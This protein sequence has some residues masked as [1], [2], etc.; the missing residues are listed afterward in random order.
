MS[1]RQDAG[2]GYGL[3]LR[4]AHYGEILDRRPAVDWFEILSENYFVRGGKPM[5]FL[6]RIRERYPI[7]MHGVG[8]SIGGTDPLDRRYLK[9][10]AALVRRVDPCRVSD[11]LCWTGVA[12]RRLHDLMPLPY[13]EEALEH[14]AARIGAIQ[15]A[16]GRRILIEN[17]SSYVA[18]RA[19]TMAEWTFLAEVARRADCHILLDVNNVYVAATNHGFD[20][21]R[22]LDALPVDRVREMH[23][24]GHSRDGS[25][26][27]DTHD[28]PVSDAVWD[29]YGDA[30]GRF[31]ALPT[32]IERDD[33][34]PPLAEL[35]A[36]LDRAR[37]IADATA[38][39]RTTTLAVR[40]AGGRSDRRA[41]PDVAR[42]GRA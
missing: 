42:I 2:T 18:Y 9:D 14:V 20:P 27:V 4:P 40:T 29:L 8:L 31:G 30:V 15:D 3:G 12:G 38:R 17:V 26:L 25:L 34:I 28:A 19:S 33:R 11:H 7:S 1:A 23:L 16:L 6:D 41:A 36:E 24:A 32:M 13:T 39:G 10:L 5:H 22:Y 35:I 21:R 37:R